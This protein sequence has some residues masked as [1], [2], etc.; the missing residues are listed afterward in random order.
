MKLV[1]WFHLVDGSVIRL[2]NYKLEKGM[3]ISKTKDTE[4]EI[5][6]H[7]I[8]YIEHNIDENK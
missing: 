5:P 1:H 8:A 2:T 6:F 4:V 3:Y 7:A